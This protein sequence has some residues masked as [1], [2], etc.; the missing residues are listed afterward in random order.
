MRA[1]VAVIAWVGVLGLGASRPPDEWVLLSGTLAKEL[2]SQ[3]SRPAPADYDDTW[4]PAVSDIA[5]L[6]EHLK[7]LEKLTTSSCC[8]PGARIGDVHSYR[9]Q[10]VGLVLKGRKI[11]YI[12][13]F[14][15][16][17]TESE[18]RRKPVLYCDGGESFWG[19]TFDPASGTFSDLAFNGVA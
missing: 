3:C 16:S 17:A 1:L 13:A 7:E 18:W 4:D 2:T 14:R 11:I 12:N 15:R 9:R 10:Y 8:L 19:A 5:R 6:E